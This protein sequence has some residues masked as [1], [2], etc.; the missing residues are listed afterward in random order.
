MAEIEQCEC[1]QSDCEE[2]EQR[3]LDLEDE[4]DRSDMIED[5]ERQ[6]DQSLIK[7]LEGG[8]EDDYDE[9][10]MQGSHPLSGSD[11]EE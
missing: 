6:E 2:C 9:D 10:D 8:D 4:K 5:I 3:R 1:N 7:E 11:E